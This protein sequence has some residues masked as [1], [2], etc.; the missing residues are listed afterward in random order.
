MKRCRT[1]NIFAG[2]FLNL[3]YLTRILP[4]RLQL[5][6]HHPILKFPIETME[7][8]QSKDPAELEQ[9]VPPTVSKWPSIRTALFKIFTEIAT[10]YP[11]GF[12][13]GK[14]SPHL[15]D[16]SL[17]YADICLEPY[18]KF[19]ITEAIISELVSHFCPSELLC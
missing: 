15:V 6:P 17:F 14:L 11:L 19:I 12:A 9:A 16:W 3:E 4:C 8:Q 18:R 5:F 10:G 7:K 1:H 2:G 13:I